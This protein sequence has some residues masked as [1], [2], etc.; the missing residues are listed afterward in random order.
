MPRVNVLPSGADG[1]ETPWNDS[2]WSVILHGDTFMST[3]GAGDTARLA[4]VSRAARREFAETPE[5]LW[6]SMFAGQSREELARLF[7]RAL[8]AGQ[9]AHVARALRAARDFGAGDFR[10]ELLLLRDDNQQNEDE[11]C[12]YACAMSNDVATARVLLQAAREAGVLEALLLLLNLGRSCLLPCTRDGHPEMLE[13]LLTCAAAGLRVG[14]ELSCLRLLLELPADDDEDNGGSCLYFAVESGDLRTM[15]VLLAA[16]HSAGVQLLD[17]RDRSDSTCLHWAAKM[18]GAR[19]VEMLL[20]AGGAAGVQLLLARNDDGDTC[21]HTAV[22][23]RNMEVVRALLVAGGPA[24]ALAR[25]E[26]GNTAL[27]D[28]V[29]CGDLICIRMLLDVGGRALLL[30]VDD[31]LN[32]C[33]HVSAA[34][35]CYSEMGQRSVLPVMNMLLEFAH[36]LDDSVLGEVL[37]LRNGQGDS[38]LMTATAYRHSGIM[39]ALLRYAGMAGVEQQLLMMTDDDGDSCLKHAA[40]ASDEA[41]WPAER[42]SAPVLAAL[43]DSPFARELVMLHD[44]DGYTALRHAAMFGHAQAVR[45]LL[46]APGGP[47]VLA[48]EGRAALRDARSEGKLDV[49]AVLV[50]F[51][52]PSEQ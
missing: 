1:R 22:E 45:A 15:E 4:R 37:L 52:F 25:G 19:Q 21:L 49:A 8:R 14:G 18:G 26:G 35:V 13:L 20:E 23:F 38:C 47:E 28:A 17:A 39:R 46:E 33:V 24:L 10:A 34:R 5:A 27:H 6:G 16:G 40:Q 32:S 43:L 11:G 42:Q 44:A 12:L 2:M 51:I 30:C 48:A 3:L 31:T 36:R 29:Q 9:T 7:W 50:K 41:P